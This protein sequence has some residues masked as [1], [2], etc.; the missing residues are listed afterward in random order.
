MNTTVCAITITFNPDL[1]IFERQLQSLHAQCDVSLVDNGSEPNVL[2]RIEQL[3]QRYGCRL[4][5]L[6]ENEGIATAQNHG[7]KLI[8]NERPECE[9]LLFLDHDS[10][11]K[12]DFVAAMVEEYLRLERL[13]GIGVL[14]SAIVAIRGERG[15]DLPAFF[16]PVLELVY[17]A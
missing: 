12:P 1:T 6:G 2:R 10:I 3:S 8:E 15:S 17:A 7:V 11:P 14:G 5:A 13:S 9:Y 16:G 4:L